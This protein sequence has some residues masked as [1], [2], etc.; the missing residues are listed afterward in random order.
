[1]AGSGATAEPDCDGKWNLP[2]GH[3]R[4]NHTSMSGVVR[5]P[6]VSEAY[7]RYGVRGLATAN[8]SPKDLV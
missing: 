2:G 1:M 7:A 8:R 5:V 6:D 3:E 4:A